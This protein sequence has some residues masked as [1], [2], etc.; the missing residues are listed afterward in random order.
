MKPLFILLGCISPLLLNAENK[1]P[2]FEDKETTLDEVLSVDTK[3]LIQVI[4]DQ[5]ALLRQGSIERAYQ[6][7]TSSEFR[8]ATLFDQFKKFVTNYPVFSKN[9]SFQFHAMNFQAH[10]ATV[11][12]ALISKSGDILQAEYDLIKEDGKWK[13][14]GIE[15]YKPAASEI[16]SD[17]TSS[18]KSNE[19]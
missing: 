17:D 8:K 12:G 18:K 7:Y 11:Q 14:L 3:Q 1:E 19:I 4:E 5:L 6:E 2:R 16:K 10:V 15:I 13:I 9:Q